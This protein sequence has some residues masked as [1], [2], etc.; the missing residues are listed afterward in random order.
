MAK[1]R[2]AE[3]IKNQKSNIEQR[4]AARSINSYH[5]ENKQPEKDFS[6]IDFDQAQTQS[7]NFTSNASIKGV[8]QR[9]SLLD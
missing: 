2:D 6:D 4:K 3:V 9:K 7:I 8:P 1:D 5:F